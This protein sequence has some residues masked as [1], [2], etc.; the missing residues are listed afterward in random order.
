MNW[1]IDVLK[2]SAITTLINQNEDLHSR[3]SVQIRKNALAEEQIHKLRQT[4]EEQKSQLENLKDQ[5]IIYRKKDQVVS[6]RYSK[7]DQELKKYQDRIDFLELKYSEYYST[8]SNKLELITEENQL[9]ESRSR[10]LG[11]H[12]SRLLKIANIYKSEI[13]RLKTDIDEISK[14][15]ETTQTQLG[16]AANHIQTMSKNNKE[17]IDALES[18]YQDLKTHSSNTISHLHDQIDELNEKLKQHNSVVELNISLKNNIVNLTRQIEA[19]DEE[20]Q[21]E[22]ERIQ[23]ELGRYRMEAKQKTVELNQIE[24]K[25]EQTLALAEKSEKERKE[26]EEENENIRILWKEHQSENEKLIEQNQSLQKLNRQLSIKMNEYRSEIRQL[27]VQIEAKTLFN[28]D[29]KIGFDEESK[30]AEEHQQTL[31]KIDHLLQEIQTGFV[32]QGIKED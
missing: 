29:A 20:T 11:R 4:L 28:R 12:K 21:N 19:R 2:S 25:Y 22:I 8:N 27:K 7:V 18:K 30:S 26:A 5:V 15:V 14:V 17:N 24:K 32:G 31:N 3:L 9:L 1:P 23:S 13:T 16:E 10:R 6:S